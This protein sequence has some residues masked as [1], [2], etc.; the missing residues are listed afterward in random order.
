MLTPL[1]GAAFFFGIGMYLRIP[2]LDEKFGR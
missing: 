2:W 1:L